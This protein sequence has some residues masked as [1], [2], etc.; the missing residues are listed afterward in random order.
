MERARRYVRTFTIFGLIV[1]LL[2][3]LPAMLKYGFWPGVKASIMIT[4][5]GTFIAA[6]MII[7]IDY[8][9]TRKLPSEALHLAQHRELQIKGA[10]NQIFNQCQDI[11]EKIEFIKKVTPSKDKMNISAL[12]KRSLISNGENITLQFHI[13]SQDM[14]T[15]DINSRPV[16]RF[17]QLDFG[18][19]FRNVESISKM[20]ESKLK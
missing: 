12:T 17:T 14:T 8:I 16:V 2:I 3:I 7:P 6:I 20:I 9:M 13:L 10:L 11:L 15:I 5:I 19:N 4:V 1:G 18:K